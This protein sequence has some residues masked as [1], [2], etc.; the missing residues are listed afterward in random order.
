MLSVAPRNIQV[1]SKNIL[2]KLKN[3]QLIFGKKDD[4]E[5]DCFPTLPT[6]LIINIFSYLQPG[7]ISNVSRVCR[8]FHKIC[9]TY[10]SS[11]ARFNVPS[12]AV[13]YGIWRDVLKQRI[14]CGDGA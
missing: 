6:E 1:S 12:M 4:K 14:V 2:S 11:F 13:C 3:I 9:M 10:R 7:C 8:R 5:E